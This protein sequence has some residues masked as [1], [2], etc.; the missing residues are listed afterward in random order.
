[1]TTVVLLLGPIVY[2]VRFWLYKMAKFPNKLDRWGWK[3]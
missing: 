1:M 2:L 3:D